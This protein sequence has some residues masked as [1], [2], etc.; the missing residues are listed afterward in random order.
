ME[1]TRKRTLVYLLPN[2]FTA[3]NLFCGFMA[4]LS[5][6]EGTIQRQAAAEGWWLYYERSLFFIIGAFLCDMLDGRVARLGGQ[7]S[8]FGREFDS[9]AD[10]VS[11][12][13]APALLVFKIVLAELPNKV[14]WLI[15][16]IYLACGAL[17]LARF[18]VLA[19]DPEAKS[20]K[21]FRGFPIPAAA[22]LIASITLLLLQVYESDREIGLWKYFLAALMLFLSFM[23]FSRFSYPSF[24]ALDWRTRRSV[25]QLLGAVL[26]LGVVLLNYRY[27]LAAVFTAYLLYGFFRPY[28]S[29]RWRPNPDI[30]EEA[31]EEQSPPPPGP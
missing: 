24:K 20:L 7:E 3:G 1:P 26:V 27:A 30:E 15:A 18:N 10:I 21:E 2:L 8:P 25:P 19:A 6:F 4:V 12:G 22:G 28:L 13:V 23:M 14:G 31:V 9:L 11:F 5:I 29:R 17:R 16:F